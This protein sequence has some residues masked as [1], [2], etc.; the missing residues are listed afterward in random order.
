MEI[1]KAGIISA[2]LGEPREVEKETSGS[3]L[4]EAE[5]RQNHGDSWK[6]VSRTMMEE[7]DEAGDEATKALREK[8][9]EMIDALDLGK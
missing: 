5:S 8:Q 7:L 6:S 1:R 9:R 3:G 4:H 2:E